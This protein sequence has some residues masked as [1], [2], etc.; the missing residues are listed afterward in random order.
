MLNTKA[1]QTE[2]RDSLHQLLQEKPLACA[3][4][5]ATGRIQHQ[6]SAIDLRWLLFQLLCIQGDWARAL[7]QLQIWASLSTD[8]LRTAQMLRELLRA[9]AYRGEVMK[10]MKEPGWLDARPAWPGQMAQ[11]LRTMASGDAA[12][13]DTLRRNALDAA[14]EA[15]GHANPGAEFAWI[16]DSDSRLGPTCELMFSGGYR[17][18]PFSQIATLSFPPVEGALDLVWRQCKVT[19]HDQTELSAYMPSRYP[20]A[21]DASD[22]QKLGAETAW[23]ESSETTVIGAGQRTWMTDAG[24]IAMLNVLSMHFQGQSIECA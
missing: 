13:A 2:T 24:D 23:H 15:A 12:H 17:W 14:P 10:G 21:S 6:P 16:S 8:H 1:P 22:A 18:V 11:A 3:I 20:L 7:K 19:L 5:E 9:E 4:D